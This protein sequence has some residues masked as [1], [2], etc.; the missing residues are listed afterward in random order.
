MIGSGISRFSPVIWVPG[1][2]LCYGC[3]PSSFSKVVPLWNE[4]F[5]STLRPQFWLYFTPLRINIRDVFGFVNQGDR[6][7][8]RRTLDDYLHRDDSS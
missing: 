2:L 6:A 3:A 1:S 5:P 7:V 4:T 8:R